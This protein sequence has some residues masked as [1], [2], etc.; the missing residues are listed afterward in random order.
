MATDIKKC[1]LWSDN[2][3]LHDTELA[4]AAQEA[5]ERL[6]QANVKLD[7]D[8][9]KDIPE[10]PAQESVED[11]RTALFLRWTALIQVLGHSRLRGKGSASV[12]LVRMA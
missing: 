12:R 10:A 2:K 1:P 5:R 11:A 6:K 8:P 4:K 7:I 3:L 9:L